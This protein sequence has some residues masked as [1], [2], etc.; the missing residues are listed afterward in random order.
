MLQIDDILSSRLHA[1]R[2][3]LRRFAESHR[4]SELSI[5]GS[6]LR[7]DFAP[8]S[9]VDILFALAPGET[10]SIEKYLAMKDELESLFGRAVDL[11]EKPLLTNPIR[12]DSILGSRE[13][14][15]AA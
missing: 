10:M 1:D 11:V 14:V 8:E 9:D 3:R 15:Y 13:V 7:D 2:E 12:R 6:A 4:L 5:F